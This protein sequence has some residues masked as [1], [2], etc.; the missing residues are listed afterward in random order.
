E[1]YHAVRE[2]REK[3]PDKAV[4]Y[5]ADGCD[6]HGWAVFMAGGSLAN[7]PAVGGGFFTAAA[8]MKPMGQWILGGK[9]GM[10]I[11]CN[12]AGDVQADL[13]GMDGSFRVHRIDPVSG[14]ISKEAEKVRGGKMVTLAAGG[15]GPV[16]LWIMK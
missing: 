11:Y 12:K 14:V 4:M 1:V 3:F 6:N 15:K 5:T 13:T 2:Y 9:D 8:K 10:I 16:M 7:V